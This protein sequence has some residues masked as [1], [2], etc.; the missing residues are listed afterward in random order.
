MT[1]PAP[2]PWITNRPP[3]HSDADPKQYVLVPT[4][5]DMHS[6]QCTV[7]HWSLA[8]QGYLPWRHT[9]RWVS[10]EPEPPAPVIV[11]PE[12]EP[13]EAA[14]E[15]SD[16]ITDRLPKSFDGDED[17][18][19]I[20]YKPDAKYKRI[21]MYWSKVRIGTPWKHTTIWKPKPAPAAPDP[22]PETAAPKFRVGQVWRTRG[23]VECT[24]KRVCVSGVLPI[25]TNLYTHHL[26]ELNGK[27]ILN[28]GKDHED[29]LVEPISEPSASEPPTPAPTAP[30]PE[31]K[32]EPE[33]VAPEISHWI[34]DRLPT[35]ADGDEDG[36]V[37]ICTSP[38]LSMED[39]S[40][41]KWYHVTLE[42]PWRHCST[43]VPPEPEPST[44]TAPEPE[45][46]KARR[47]FLEFV[48]LPYST[49][50][51]DSAV[52]TDNTAWV[53]YR[54]GNSD[55]NIWIKV[56]PLPQPGEE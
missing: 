11:T 6:D 10:P 29:D 26:H 53:R 25:M 31:P 50:F 39:W 4:G 47:G 18:V 2:A 17:G 40:Y 12:P 48:R 19:V 45:P 56:L 8:A 34:T 1:T 54:V 28:Q 16:W 46:E 3:S 15:F 55:D 13:K 49:G 20:I 9:S 44:P 21:L 51:L 41:E 24:V 14:L 7:M 5:I 35:K 23:G 33:A 22:E 42:W 32:P 36:D 27:S 37:K 30:E 43:W 38:R 52:G